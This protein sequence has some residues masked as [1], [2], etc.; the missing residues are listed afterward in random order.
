[1]HPKPGFSTQISSSFFYSPP[2]SVVSHTQSLQNSCSPPLPP[3]ATQ[4]ALPQ[5]IRLWGK[6]ERYMNIIVVTLYR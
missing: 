6:D 2:P 3:C 4:N 5:H 1:M